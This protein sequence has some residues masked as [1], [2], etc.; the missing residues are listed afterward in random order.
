MPNF[1]QERLRRKLSQSEVSAVAGISQPLLSRFENRQKPL[2]RNV[3]ARVWGA[4]EILEDDRR[5][6]D[7]AL[8]IGLLVLIA[9][10]APEARR[11]ARIALEESE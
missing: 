4:L 8:D 6:Q 11:L 9:G 1:R 7:A 5:L 3:E 10:V 2:S